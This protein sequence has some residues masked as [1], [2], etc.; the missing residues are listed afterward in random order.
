MGWL[1]KFVGVE[2]IFMVDIFDF[3]VVRSELVLL[4]EKVWWY[5]ELKGFSGLILIL[6]VKFV[7][8]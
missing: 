1:C 2:D 5:C 3:E 7:D 8:F 6:K 4:V